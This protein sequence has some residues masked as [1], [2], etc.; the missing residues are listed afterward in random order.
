MNDHI[1]KRSKDRCPAHPGAVLRED[2]IPSVKRSKSEIARL[3]GI[4]R[5][6]LNDILSERKPMSPQVAVRV[7]KLFGGGA[8][9]WVRMQAAFDT[10]HAERNVDVSDIQPLKVA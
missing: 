4:S 1:A 3:L 5:Q 7:G 8:A 2:V 6:H 9:P 10:W